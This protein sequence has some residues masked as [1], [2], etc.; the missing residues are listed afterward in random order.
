[1]GIEDWE[2]K[3]SYL[4]KFVRPELERAFKRG[5]NKHKGKNHHTAPRI[6]AR[7]PDEDIR[8][9]RDL[10]VLVRLLE[11]EEAADNED[12]QT[13]LEKIES[14]IGYLVILHMRTREKRNFFAPEETKEGEIS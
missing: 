6:M 14:A 9:I 7:R 4:D 3:I 10:H 11:A 2:G 1:M 5:D 8:H 12:I 13:A